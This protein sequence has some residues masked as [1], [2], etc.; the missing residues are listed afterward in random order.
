[1]LDIDKLRRYN[2]DGENTHA[3]FFLVLNQSL[4]PL[5]CHDAASSDTS[6]V[7]SS[8]ENLVILILLSL[9]LKVTGNRQNFDARRT[10]SLVSKSPV[11]LLNNKRQD[12]ITWHR[13]A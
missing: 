13:A 3:L 1:M 11:S 2:D 9:Y 8:I 7:S 12:L 6:N 10:P 5:L 4:S